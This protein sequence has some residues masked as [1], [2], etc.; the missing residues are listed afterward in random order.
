MP[1]LILEHS[2]NVALPDPV[3]DLL[4]D[5]HASLAETAG[6]DPA[7][8]KSRIYR[9]DDFFVGAAETG[10]GALERRAFIHLQVSLLPGR[11]DEEKSRVADG[12]LALL[13]AAILPENQRLDLQITVDIRDLNR[14]AYAKYVAYASENDRPS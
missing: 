7:G 12:C 1:H 5:L 10:T 9:S 13:K 3:R 11:S 8:C 4:S 14:V 6:V 2:S